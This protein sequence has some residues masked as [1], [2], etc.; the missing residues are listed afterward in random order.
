V[1]AMG[2]GN[3]IRIT[4]NNQSARLNVTATADQTVFTV[5][6]GYKVPHLDVYR[7]GVK[8]VTGVDYTALDGS[9]CTLVSPASVGDII[10]FAVI[11]DFR[12]ADVMGRN[13]NQTLNGD[14]SVTGII[15]AQGNINTNGDYF[16]DGN[17][18]TD[19]LTALTIALGF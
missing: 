8:L 3:P 15:T 18:Y 10:E 14:L 6:S 5:T 19:Y 11:E 1:P 2:I 13:S 9:S 4:N 17:S 7:N 16:L 12:V